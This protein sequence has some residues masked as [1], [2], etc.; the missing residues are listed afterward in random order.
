MAKAVIVGGGVAGLSA[1]I[2]AQ[3]TGF[4]TEILEAH[5]KAGGNLTG[6]DRGEYHIDNCIHWLTG[7]NPV[8]DL[9]GMW[10]TLGALGGVDIPARDALYLL[11]G[12]KDAFSDQGYRQIRAGYARLFRRR[13]QGDILAD[14]RNPRGNDIKR[15]LCKRQ[16]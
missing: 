2:F 15:Y 5:Q 11:S 7:T 9:Y 10:E 8:T 16:S 6:W 12:R 14:Q 4:D 1:G 3:L 13:R